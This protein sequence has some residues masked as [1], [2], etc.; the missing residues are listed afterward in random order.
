MFIVDLTY[1]EPIEKVEALLEA[2]LAWLQKYF[3]AGDFVASGR[4]VPRIGGIILT[5]T[6]ARPDLDKILAEDPFTE[7]ANYS[8]TEFAPSRTS[9]ALSALQTI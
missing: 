6:L 1:E 9:E 8:I 4:K 5:R 7:V 3:A 2:H